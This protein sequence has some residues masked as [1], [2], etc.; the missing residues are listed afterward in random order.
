MCDL[1]PLILSFSVSSPV[2]LLAAI[3]W[4]VPLSRVFVHA[5]HNVGVRVYHVPFIVLFSLKLPRLCCGCTFNPPPAESDTLPAIPLSTSP[6]TYANKWQR[7]TKTRLPCCPLPYQEQWWSLSLRVSSRLSPPMYLPL[8][9]APDTVLSPPTSP[10]PKRTEAVASIRACRSTHSYRAIFRHRFLWF[11]LRRLSVLQYRGS[12]S[13]MMLRRSLIALNWRD[14]GIS[15]VKYLNVTTEALHMAT[16][17]KARAKYSR[18]SAPNYVAMKNDSTGAME[19][20]K[21]VPAFTK[22][23]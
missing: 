7:N 13:P 6:W 8:S 1:R 9:T 23:Y 2:C 10:R 22:D 18:F 19:E 20:V 15:Y 3:V 17:D 4:P 16:K 21:K 14:Q 11:H 12:L 5:G